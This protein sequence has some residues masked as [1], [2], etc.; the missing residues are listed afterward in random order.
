MGWVPVLLLGSIV[1]LLFVEVYQQV[2]LFLRAAIKERFAILLPAC[3]VQ[4][5][6]TIQERLLVLLFITIP[7]DPGHELS[8]L[9]FL[10][11][12]RISCRQNGLGH[13]VEEGDVIIREVNA[14]RT[15]ILVGIAAPGQESFR[16]E[17]SAAQDKCHPGYCVSSVHVVMF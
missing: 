13:F 12:G 14:R 4:F 16:T 1:L 8:H 6:H 5:L 11:S 3:F 2:M 10:G 15:D 9:G 7:Y 17:D